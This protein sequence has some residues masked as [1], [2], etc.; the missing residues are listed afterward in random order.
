MKKT[1]EDLY[2]NAV[3]IHEKLIKTYTYEEIVDLLIILKGI[4]QD[5]IIQKNCKFL[6]RKVY[7]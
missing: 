5:Y 1:A 6:D 7:K 4:N 3:K 2:Y